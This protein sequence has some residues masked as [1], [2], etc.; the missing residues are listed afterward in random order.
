[1]QFIDE[2]TR[3]VMARGYIILDKLN[4]FKEINSQRNEEDNSSSSEFE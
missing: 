1:M 4:M 3:K 2:E